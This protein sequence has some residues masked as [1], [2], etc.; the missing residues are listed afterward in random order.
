[1]FGR[2]ADAALPFLPPG[3]KVFETGAGGSAL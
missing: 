2:L 1:M 3:P